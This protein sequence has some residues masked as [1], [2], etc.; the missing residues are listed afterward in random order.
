MTTPTNDTTPVQQ[1][2]PVTPAPSD[3]QEFDAALTEI[4][5]EDEGAPAD[6]AA[7]QDPSLDQSDQSAGDT[8][9]P[10]NPDKGEAAE[11]QQPASNTNSPAGNSQNDPW[12]NA[13]DELR[14]IH[15]N[16][17]RDADLRY[18]SAATRQSAADRKI[19]EQKAE[20]E[21]LRRGSSNEGQQQ[22]GDE[23]S[24]NGNRDNGGGTD[25]KAQL[26]QLREDY[27]DVAVPILEEMAAM[28]TEL[29]RVSGTANTFEQQ[30]QIAF[31]GQQVAALEEKHPD[32]LDL[33]KPEAEGG[34]KE[35]YAGW[36]TTQPR[37]I[38]EAAR[39]NSEVI[40]D[41]SEAILVVDRFKAE[42]GINTN[43][44]APSQAQQAATAQQQKRE[45][46]LSANRDTSRAGGPAA[47]T[48]F[49]EDD[50]DGVV[51][52]LADKM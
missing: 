40:V 25:R 20:I 51:N 27:P 15:Q 6:N 28:R 11:D 10:A 30:Q 42:M 47:S 12:S 48:G 39:R 26:A 32:W 33:G 9:T 34:Y 18:R 24:E 4:M 36:L 46:Q 8:S 17:L 43:A 41:G 23:P 37:A 3:E 45:R 31:V 22:Q 29:A 7:A 2:A 13:P 14:N 21:R 1:D 19:A 35:R 52:A 16:A 50:F 5:D 49:A 44:A 38:Q